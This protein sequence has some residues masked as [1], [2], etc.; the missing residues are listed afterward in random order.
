LRCYT[1]AAEWAVNIER[2]ATRQ[3]SLMLQALKAGAYTRS[4]FG[5]T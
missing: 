1:K 3:L 2:D 5:A 4:L